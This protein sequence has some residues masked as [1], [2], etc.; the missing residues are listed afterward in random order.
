[1]TDPL[2]LFP[3]GCRLIID[4][5]LGDQYRIGYQ[6]GGVKYVPGSGSYY[7]FDTAL[8]KCW[9]ALLENHPAQPDE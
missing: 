2:L 8:R 6:W 5:V 9:E 1:M 4:K 3:T 7:D